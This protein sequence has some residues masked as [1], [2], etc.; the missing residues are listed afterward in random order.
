VAGYR[1]IDN[2]VEFTGS[3]VEQQAYSGHVNLLYSPTPEVVL[4]IEYLYADRELESGVDGNIN[5]VQFSGKY[6]F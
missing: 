2:P 3:N 1:Q 4:G 6:V 5:R